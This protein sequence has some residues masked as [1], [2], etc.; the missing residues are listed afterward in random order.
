MTE[1]LGV[2]MAIPLP[3][4]IRHCLYELKNLFSNVFMH[5]KY[6]ILFLLFAYSLSSLITLLILIFLSKL[7]FSSPIFK[8]GILVFPYLQL[9][10][11]FGPPSFF[12]MWHDQG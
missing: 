6:K 8:T 4:K 10:R 3:C 2:T 11:Y 1:K 7:T 12:M 5:T 9:F